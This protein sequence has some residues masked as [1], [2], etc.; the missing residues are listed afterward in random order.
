MLRFLRKTDGG[1]PVKQALE[2]QKKILVILR[3]ENLKMTKLKVSC[4]RSPQ[5]PLFFFHLHH[6]KRRTFSVK[7]WVFSIQSD[8]NL[9]RSCH[10]V[11]LG[12]G[13]EVQEPAVEPGGSASSG[14]RC[15]WA[16]R[17][18]AAGASDRPQLHARGGRSVEEMAALTSPSSLPPPPT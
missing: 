1:L 3:E 8:D 4:P 10:A 2:E 13:R 18:S 14:G 12:G 9:C 7:M 5:E 17:R 11:G 16:G 15:E 6:P